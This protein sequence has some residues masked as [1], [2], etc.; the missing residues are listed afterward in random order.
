MKPSLYLT[1]KDLPAIKNWKVG[2]IYEVKVKIKQ[3]SMNER[4][5]GTHSGS[6]EVQE[7][8]PVKEQKDDLAS[9]N[10]LSSNKDFMKA[11]ARMKKEHYII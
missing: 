8:E 4:D 11:S 5:D 7:I 3:K 1:S 6:F 10:A 2:E 9:V